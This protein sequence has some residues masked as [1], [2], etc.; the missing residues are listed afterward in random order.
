MT[1]QL[2]NIEKSFGAARAVK[3]VSFSLSQGEVLSLLGP[4][5]CGKTTTLRMIAGFE[6]PTAGTITLAGRDITHTPARKRNIG[7]VFQS[8]ALFPHMSVAD[9][10]AFGLK[11]RNISRADRDTRIKEALD[12]VRMSQFADRS[13]KR[14]SGGQQQRVALARALVIKPDILLLDEP[15]SALDLKLREEMRD[16]I[17]RIVRELKI[18]TVFVTHD[19]SEALVLSDFVAVMNG[20]SIEQLDTPDRLYRYPQTAFVADFIGGA[21][22]IKGSINGNRTFVCS[23]GQVINLADDPAGNVEHIAIRPEDIQLVKLGAAA[24]LTGRIIQTRFLGGV[25]E[26]VITDSGISMTVRSNS[27]TTFKVGDV[28]GLKL[29]PE[30]VVCLRNK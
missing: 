23:G 20:G 7:M 22:V 5:G 9:N 30:R 19:Q 29:H 14:L 13:P 25:T 21:N 1:L 16:E 28:V 11:M 24:E 27:Y 6:E 18:T 17:N 12:I 15:L 8:Y 26:Y 2:E 10:V 3:G 4:S